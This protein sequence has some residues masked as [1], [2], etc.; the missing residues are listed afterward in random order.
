MDNKDG[1]K[2]KMVA[3]DNL[4]KFTNICFRVRE[5]PQPIGLIKL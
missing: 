2:D 4:L 5:K 1:Y 3:A